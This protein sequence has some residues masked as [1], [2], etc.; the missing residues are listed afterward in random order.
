M[1]RFIGSGTLPRAA[2]VNGTEKKAVKF[3]LAACYGYNS[4]TKRDLIAYV[5]CVVFEP[6][7]QQFRRLARSAR[8]G[9]RLEAVLA[10]FWPC[11]IPL[12]KF[13]FARFLFSCHDLIYNSISVCM[14]PVT[15]G[16]AR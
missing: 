8:S 16:G 10:V 13:A 3:T 1:N 14:K 4:T 2:K 6:A 11:E 9:V 7:P 15:P 12:S 5:P